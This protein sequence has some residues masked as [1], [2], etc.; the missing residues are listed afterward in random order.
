VRSS[1]STSSRP[2]RHQPVSKAPAAP[3]HGFPDARGN[4]GGKSRDSSA[5]CA[6][7]LPKLVFPAL[8]PPKR[9]RERVSAQLF[10]TP[11]WHN[12][13]ESS[14]RSCSRSCAKG[15][16]KGLTRWWYGEWTKAL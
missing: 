13:V 2:S 9:S 8:P 10:F 7:K 6:M 15:T 11:A 3:P 16:L 5:A 4:K 12:F 1:V 14:F